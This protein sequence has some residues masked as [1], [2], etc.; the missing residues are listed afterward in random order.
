MADKPQAEGQTAARAGKF[1]IY[2][3]WV[4][5]LILLTLGFSDLLKRQRNPNRDVA[6]ATGDDG[7]REV[8]LKRN[9]HG[10]YVATGTING[11]SVEFFV[12]TGATNIAVSAK[13]AQRLGLTAGR[14]VRVS[15]ANGDTLA[16]M[17]SLDSIALGSIALHELRATITPQMFDDTVLLGMN[18]LK[19]IDFAQQGDTLILTQHPRR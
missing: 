11:Q 6:T 10:H 8:R 7:T 19:E 15:T 5:L 2:G 4:L 3:A 18:F 16:Y 13:L 14:P 9:R 17:T 12:D 1:M